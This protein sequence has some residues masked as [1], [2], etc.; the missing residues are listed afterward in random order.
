MKGKLQ[1]EKLDSKNFDDFVQMIAL[2]AAYEQ[3]EPPDAP[4]LARLKRDAL[5]DHPKFEGYLLRSDRTTVGY[6]L[7]YLTYSSYLSLPVFHIEDLFLI[8]SHRRRGYGKKI[9]EFC[10]CLADGKGCGR[11]EWTVYTWNKPAIAFYEKIGATRLDK[12]E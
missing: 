5:G 8:D 9:I 6:F 2:L 4:A 10:I 3:Q 12:V 1:F 7:F 11:M